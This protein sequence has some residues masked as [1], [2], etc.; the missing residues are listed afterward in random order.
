MKDLNFRYYNGR[1][2]IAIILILAA[3]LIT[4]K[5]LI[6]THHFSWVH[7]AQDFAVISTIALVMGLINQYAMFPFYLKLLGLTNLRGE[8]KGYLTSSFH[9]DDDP[10]KENI[11]KYMILEIAQN[12][13]DIEIFIT[14]FNSDD[15]STPTSTSKSNWVQYRA[16]SN[17]NSIIEYS[18]SST[19]NKI[20][21]DDK[22]YGLT[23]HWG[24]SSLTYNPTDKTLTG[25][26]FTYENQSFGTISLTL[27]K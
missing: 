13:N 21:P 3:A 6:A 9:V 18:Y 20:H 22:K 2:L 23:A 7:F 8:Y 24:F 16:L 25:F 19:P 27:N 14:L 1:L 15:Y 17:G 11:K 12:I 4:V 26:Y 5:Q 10:D